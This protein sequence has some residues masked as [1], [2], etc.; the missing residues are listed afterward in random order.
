MSASLLG[1]RGVQRRVAGG[2]RRGLGTARRTDLDPDGVSVGAQST[3]LLHDGE[4]LLG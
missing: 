1:G 4:R 2:P 3:H